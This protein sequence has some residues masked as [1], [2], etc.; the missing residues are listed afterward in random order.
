MTL[1]G[2]FAQAGSDLRHKL[3]SYLATVMPSS[4]VTLVHTTLDEISEAAAAVNFRWA[5]S[6]RSG[7]RPTAWG[8]SAIR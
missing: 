7:P 8:P 3:L 1:L 2:Y 5:S 6:P 4:A